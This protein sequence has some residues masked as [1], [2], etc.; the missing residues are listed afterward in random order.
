MSSR[1]SANTR[2]TA[3]LSVGVITHSSRWFHRCRGLSATLLC[4]FSCVETN[5]AAERCFTFGLLIVN[6]LGRE[7]SNNVKKFIAEHV[8]SVMRLEVLLLLS[9]NRD[10]IWSAEAVARE[11]KLNPDSTK[12]HLDGLVSRGLLTLTDQNTQQLYTYNPSSEALD[13]TVS[14]VAAAYATQR[15]AVLSLIFASRVD[16][17]RLFTETFRTITGNLE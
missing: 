15:V 12:P 3:L 9:H 8:H 1:G 16:K 4:F 17:V 14:Q 13:K 7:L 6:V 2:L 10:T 5:A 11:L